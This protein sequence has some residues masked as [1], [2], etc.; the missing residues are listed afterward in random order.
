LIE[1]LAAMGLGLLIALAAASALVVARQGFS[2]VDAAS[3][4]RDN[5]RFVQ[6]VYSELAYKLVSKA[7]NMPRPLEPQVRRGNRQP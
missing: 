6:D 3:Q 4:P 7:C 2:N 1:L 5:G